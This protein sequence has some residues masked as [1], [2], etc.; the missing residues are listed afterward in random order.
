[1]ALARERGGDQELLP[2]IEMIATLPQFGG[3]PAEVGYWYLE[4]GRRDEARAILDGFA[5]GGFADV[6]NNWGRPSTLHDLSELAT[7]F[8]DAAIA[9]PLLELLDPYRGLLLIAYGS[10]GC[11]GAADRARGKL[12]GVLGHHDEAIAAMD[13]AMALEEH[14][15]GSALLPRTWVA[16]ARVLLA[17][18]RPE[19][20][21]RASELL[22]QAEASANQLGMTGVLQEIEH[23][24]QRGRSASAPE[25]AVD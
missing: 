5:Q 3:V 17:H 6:P 10:A 25:E 22:A 7:A 16:C 12:L 11:R 24:R 8:A 15:G 21:A 19:D 23:T 4:A 9:A 1:M 18:D 13:A 2:Q 14:V 20:R